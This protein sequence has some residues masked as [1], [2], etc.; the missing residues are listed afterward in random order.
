MVC[1]KRLL[2][3]RRSPSTSERTVHAFVEQQC[4]GA[5]L[6]YLAWLR[7]TFVRKKGSS[8]SRNI[9]KYRIR[10]KDQTGLEEIEIVGMS[11]LT[12]SRG[13]GG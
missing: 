11:I 7:Y 13:T 9:T 3:S 8:C 10:L 2:K 1:L 5:P 4:T 6:K 12:G